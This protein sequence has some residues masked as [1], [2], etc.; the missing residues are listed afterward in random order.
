METWATLLARRQAGDL[1]RDDYRRLGSRL[2]AVLHDHRGPIGLGQVEAVH[3]LREKV[4]IECSDGALFELNLNEWRDPPALLLAEG[5]YEPIETEVLLRLAGKAERFVDVGANVGYFGIRLAIANPSIEVTAIEPSPTTFDRLRRN[6]VLNE[7][8]GRFELLQVAVSDEQVTVLLHEPAATGS[9]GASMK[10]LHPGERNSSTTVQAMRLDDVVP[11]SGIDSR[12]MIL[13]MD[14]EG[15][16]AAA[17]RAGEQVLESCF[18]ALLELSRKWMAEFNSSP[19]EV[20][21]VMARRGFRCFAVS[22]DRFMPRPVRATQTID[23]LTTETNFVFAHTDR[24]E[25][26]AGAVGDL[27]A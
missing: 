18:V 25:E 15:A 19:Q 22:S 16:E 21:D 14:I 9:V 20:L 6:V 8:Q 10:E 27:I 2:S 17:L 7:L 26:F 23:S 3:V 12:S 1:S 5:C 13:K 4:L 11:L 24:I